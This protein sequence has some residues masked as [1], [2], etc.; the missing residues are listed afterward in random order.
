MG[1][2][3]DPATASNTTRTFGGNGADR[4]KPQHWPEFSGESP[5]LEN[6]RKGVLRCTLDFPERYAISL[7]GDSNAH[8]AGAPRL[9]RTLDCGSNY[10]SDEAGNSCTPSMDSWVRCVK[11]FGPPGSHYPTCPHYGQ[12]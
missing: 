7:N 8:R 3:R 5:H 2:F 10:D 12:T 9:K 4:V 11:C 6:F 1:V